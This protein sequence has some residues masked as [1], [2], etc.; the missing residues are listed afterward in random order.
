MGLGLWLVHRDGFV[1]GKLGLLISVGVWL[2]ASGNVGKLCLE[3]LWHRHYT[4]GDV[5]KKYEALFGQYH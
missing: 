3:V 1:S 5:I 2:E 4:V